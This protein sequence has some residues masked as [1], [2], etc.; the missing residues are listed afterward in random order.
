MKRAVRA[1][2]RCLL[3]LGL[4]G[5]LLIAATWVSTW[6]GEPWACD[7]KSIYISAAAGQIWVKTDGQLDFDFVAYNRDNTYYQKPQTGRFMAGFKPTPTFLSHAIKDRLHVG[8]WL[9]ESINVGGL[10]R[11]QSYIF[12]PIWMPLL[13]SAGVAAVGWRLRGRK[14]RPDQCGHCGYNLAGLNGGPCPE[15]GRAPPIPG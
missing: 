9:P 2:G 13:L 8:R 14:P 4:T 6:F 15:C 10:A 11:P 5:A 3:W 12:I 1:I 7:R